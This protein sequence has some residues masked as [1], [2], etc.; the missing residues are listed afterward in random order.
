MLANAANR[1]E[2]RARMLDQ[3]VRQYSSTQGSRSSCRASRAFGDHR[4]IMGLQPLS[5]TC[6]ARRL[7]CW[8]VSPRG[9]VAIPT[10]VART[11][12]KVA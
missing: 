11:L 9:S 3:H 7:L 4:A 6:D 1:S 5:S 10:I 8:L 12:A 2:G